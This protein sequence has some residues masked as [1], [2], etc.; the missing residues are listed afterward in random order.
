MIKN[1]LSLYAST[2]LVLGLSLLLVITGLFG[3]FNAKSQEDPSFPYRN[4]FIQITI[5]GQSATQ[6]N[7]SIVK[8]L[9]RSLAKIE[10]INTIQSRIRFGNATI[11]IE[12]NEQEY[13]TDLIWQRIKEEVAPFRSGLNGGSIQVMD[14][15]Q[16]TQ[17]IL[18]VVQ[19]GNGLAMDRKI[20]VKI[21]DE[22]RQLAV[23]REATLIGDPGIE[24]A[25]GYSQHRML[26]LGLTPTAIAQQLRD[27]NKQNNLGV[28]SNNLSN[29]A[30]L[31]I[32]HLN[33]DE[34]IADVQLT[35]PEGAKVP[36]G[37]IA[38][39]H[40]RAQPTATEQFWKNGEQVI[41]IALS[42]PP[43]QVNIEA[44]GNTIKQAVTDI[45]TRYDNTPVSIEI[46]Q[47]DWSEKRRDGLVNSLIQSCIGIGVI[48]LLF[49]SIQSAV[50]ISLT[51]P[52]IVLSSIALFTTF[53][54][55]IHQM[56]I[57]GLVLSLGLM[58]DNCI[59]IA[60]RLS[61]HSNK[62][63]TVAKA[64]TR[65]VI[66]LRK[67]LAAATATTIAAFIPMLLAKGSVADFIATIPILVIICISLS[68]LAALILI[69]I[70]FAH[71]HVSNTGLEKWQRHFAD[72]LSKLGYHLSA[73]V[74]K[75]PALTLTLAAV[76]V[77]ALLS[78][79]S[80]N[81]QFFPSANRNQIYIDVQLPLSSH[82]DITT[83]TANEVADFASRNK[84]VTDVMVFSGFS[85]PR[86]YYNLA[87]KPGET[88]I[89]RVVVTLTED[90]DPVEFSQ[91]LNSVLIQQFPEVLIKAQEL[92]Q[93]PPIESP[94]ELRLTGNDQTAL[95]NAAE[96][97]F[98]ELRQHPEV[99]SPYR[100]YSFGAPAINLDI[101][102]L[103]LSAFGLRHEEIADY[104]AWRSS[105]LR[106]TTL[107]YNF[108]PV[109][110]VLFDPSS[111][112]SSVDMVNTQVLLPQYATTALSGLVSANIVNA[113]PFIERRNGEFIMSIKADVL[114]SSDEENIL[115]TLQPTL[116][117]IAKQHL[118]K[119]S[120]G[121]ELEESEEANGALLQTL[122]FGIALLFAALMVQF[123]SYRLTALV[124]L[125]IPLGI[126]G[127]P[128]MLAI[129]GIPFGFMSILGVLA[130]MGIVVNTAILLIE[131]ALNHLQQGCT[132]E[133]SI[134]LSVQNRIR[135]VIVTT[136]TTIIGMLPLTSSA[137]PLW[138]PLAWAVIG[139]LLTSTLLSMLVLPV[140]LKLILA[141]KRFQQSQNITQKRSLQTN[142][143]ANY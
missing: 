64:I 84:H 126:I 106:V 62:G 92:G 115:Q 100:N 91:S 52:A 18:L 133:E 131:N 111:T 96:A 93:G 1:R 121:G 134:C 118:V 104:I 16:D 4:G 120:F 12:L 26:A 69:P 117:G 132:L 77:T 30:L 13:N 37:S 27:A 86:F 60:E 89:A 135:P 83:Q 19:T 99:V 7:D 142:E 24:L 6:L 31:P 33:Q 128:A 101:D 50:I 103:A 20:A 87:Q 54:G 42:L 49:L 139:G 29:L 14:R 88:H 68:Y 105:G 28:L 71:I 95:F 136:L 78:L 34:K 10:Q 56:T 119:L 66:E 59:I 2:R 41:G 32:N 36:L 75:K 61:H 122:P 108:E 63:V 82:I 3:W 73:L 40:Y 116:E 5:P 80:A 137:S 38:D 81:G 45:N 113:P 58:V 43:N 79:P 48:L 23:V 76:L 112:Q 124:M 67:P 140:L 65:S 44:A 125:T 47:P 21:R 70:L 46:F 9:E 114:P 94:I 72:A 123:N 15:A 17:G 25:I 97:M 102:Q 85:G 74:L 11:D 127:A 8:P 39:I 143:S 107:D 141:G 109:E 22:L 57:A 129:T 138:P 53:D 55:V 51:V 130:L 90:V 35:T 98:L 110:L